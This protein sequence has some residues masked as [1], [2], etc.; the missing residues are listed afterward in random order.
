MTPSWLASAQLLLAAGTFV[1]GCA[2][3][4]GVDQQGN[5][6][7]QVSSPPSVRYAMIVPNP[8]VLTGPV[9]VQVEGEDPDHDPV[10][11]RF[12]W[13]VNGKPLPGQIHHE[14]GPAM[15]KRGDQVS[16]EVTPTDGTNEGVPYHVSPVEVANSPPVIKQVN[17]EP[18]LAQIGDRIRA[19]V[20]GS[21]PDGDL[22]QY[23]YRWL[24]NKT[25]VSEGDQN[26]LD[27]KNF[28]R[29]DVIVAEVIPFDGRVKGK[30]VLSQPV[31]IRNHAPKITS[32]PPSGIQNGMFKY[33]VTA[34]D[35]EGDTLVYS[36]TTAP[37][38]MF[39]DRGTGYI[40]WEIP[41]DTK[42]IQHVKVV[43]EDGQGGS[44]F[45]EFEL[46]LSPP[47]ASS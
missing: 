35:P 7:K 36:L 11:F 43:T 1:I 6:S 13:I 21:D 37:P 38:G 22:V 24:R 20:E 4:D 42:G 17:L 12:Q 30:P 47:A 41:S 27:T 8:V 32:V 29:S 31:E 46:T 5:K 14:L 3:Q 25:P 18:P 40:T 45:Q 39:I 9:L 26:E 2:S 23:T 16:V 33:L 10:T 19:D 44:A 15:L 34:V 28:L